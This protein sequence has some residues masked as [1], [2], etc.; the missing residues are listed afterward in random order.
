MNCR[1]ARAVLDDFLDDSLQAAGRKAVLDH[2]AGCPECRGRLAGLDEV[3]SRLQDALGEMEPSRDFSAR[4]M[5]QVAQA[6]VPRAIRF[7]PAWWSLAAAAACL[8][9]VAGAGVVLSMSRSGTASHARSGARSPAAS[10]Q[11]D[12]S[13]L[14]GIGPAFVI[15]EAGARPYTGRTSIRTGRVVKGTPEL[16]VDAFPEGT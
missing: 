3:D 10:V 6:E 1:E 2:L 12:R 15:H 5:Q 7:R 16:I 8:L 13:Q 9:L 14:F 11:P 4:V